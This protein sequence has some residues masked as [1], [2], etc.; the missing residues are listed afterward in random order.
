MTM[1][2][3]TNDERAER[4]M[5]IVERYLKGETSYALATAFHLTR[6]RI[7]QILKKANVSYKDTPRT[8]RG[9]RYAYVGSNITK[10]M[11][12]RLLNESERTGKSLSRIIEELLEKHYR[13]KRK[14]TS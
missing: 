2:L 9:N 10:A 11:K 4:D 13:L 7:S 1:T 5:Q 14:R 12:Q 8:L 3:E 6:A